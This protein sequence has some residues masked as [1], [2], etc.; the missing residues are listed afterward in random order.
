TGHVLHED[1][2]TCQTAPHGSLMRFYQYMGAP[3]VDVL[4]EGNR[5]YWIVKQLNSAARQLGKKWQLSELYGCTGWQMNLRSHKAVGDWQALLGINLRCQHLSWYTMEG[6]SKRDYP[7]SILHQS[8]W[9][10]D[11]NLV[12]SYFARFGAI[13][14]EGSP[15]CDV[16]VLNP[17]ES[18]WCQ[19]YMGWSQWI[20]NQ[21]PDVDIIERRYTDTFNILTNNHIDFDYGEEQMM[22]SM[23][24][25]ARDSSGHTVLRVGKVSYRVV[26]VTGMLTMRRSTLELL[27]KF[28]TAGG[29]V[30]FAGELPSYIDA[31]L[32]DEI[33][34]LARHATLVSFGEEAVVSSVRAASSCYID[35]TSDGCA[36]KEVMTRVIDYGDGSTAVV[37]LNTNRE[38]PTGGLRVSIHTPRPA[39]VEEWDM[40]DGSRY[41][42]NAGTHSS[43]GVTVIE[44][45]LDAA[46]TRV[47]M[48]SPERD[49][50][51]PPRRAYTEVS[52]AAI[53]GD[54]DYSLDEPNVCVLDFARWRWTDG[55][56]DGGWHSEREVLKTDQSV[57]DDLGIERRGGEMLQPWYAKLHD[58]K[59]YGELE[60]EYE[61]YSETDQTDKLF[62][63]GER[64]EYNEYYLNGVRLTCPDRDS[65]WIDNAFKKMPIPEGTVKAGLNIVTIRVTFMRTTN[66]EAL[67]VIGKFG[68]RLDGHKKTLTPPPEK[69]GLG[70]LIDYNLPFYT[71]AVT[72]TI[73]PECYSGFT[74]AVGER[75][76]LRAASFVGSLVRIYDGERVTKLAWEPYEADITDAVRGGRSVYV[77][78]VGTRRD[79]FGPLHL[80]PLYHGAY[81]PGHFVTEGQSWTDDYNLID[82][83]LG[84]LTLVKVK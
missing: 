14:S 57:R 68:V 73:T 36:A 72:Y 13:I 37:M 32:S 4:S 58:T 77:T 18:V 51:C 41:D 81:G 74:P 1:A 2:L 24:A 20:S 22:A 34:E 69:L 25:I 5:C 50:S 28:I 79:T 44:T 83:K 80:V 78:L 27:R 9:Y 59:K 29:K 52:E 56:H 67:Y 70:N 31:K 12:E 8:P 35:V 26:V 7:A 64:P 45:S 16:L 17:I 65:F 40:L 55:E 30:I 15:R 66:I 3:G 39:S 62:L 47:F 48:L 75:I 38:K 11:Y 76:L 6:E 60:L 84:A 46:G 61:F 23:T 33:R 19:T 54:F 21:S 49:S 42:A 63:A 71:G 10:H 43:N 82:N 53:D